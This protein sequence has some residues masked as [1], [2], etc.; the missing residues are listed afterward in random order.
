MNPRITILKFGY[1][2][3]GA[4]IGLALGANELD[5]LPDWLAPLFFSTG[6]AGLVLIVLG[7]LLPRVDASDELPAVLRD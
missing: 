4:G 3:Y 1:S 5:H 7:K 2:L 6:G